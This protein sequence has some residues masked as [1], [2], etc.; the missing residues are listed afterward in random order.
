MNGLVGGCFYWCM[1]A[2]LINWSQYSSRSHLMDPEMCLDL[3]CVFS[4][5]SC[6]QDAVKRGGV[7][8]IQWRDGQ[9]WATW[10]GNT[11]S[12][13]QLE[14]MLW[15]KIAICTLMLTL[16][17]KSTP[18]LHPKDTGNTKTNNEPPCRNPPYLWLLKPS[19][20]CMPVSLLC[21]RLLTDN[22]Y[23][24]KHVCRSLPCCQLKVCQM[25][26]P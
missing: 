18:P 10:G 22:F 16:A 6:V 25:N 7:G 24:T 26:E 12:P 8:L 11:P 2:D 21:C 14:T 9:V 4:A 19:L 13:W 23:V 5:T 1:K 20:R 17:L 3:K 15:R